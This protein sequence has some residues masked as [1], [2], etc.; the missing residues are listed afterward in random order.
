LIETLGDLLVTLILNMVAAEIYQRLYFLRSINLVSLLLILLLGTTVDSFTFQKNL[1]PK[2]TEALITLGMIPQH[3]TPSSPS[4]LQHTT[5]AFMASAAAAMD[6]TS[7]ADLV[8]DRPDALLPYF[9]VGNGLL[10]PQTVKKLDDKARISNNSNSAIYLFLDTYKRCGPMACL[11]M[12][13]DPQV[14][15]HL[16]RALRESYGSK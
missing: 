5:T 14:L 15:P 1:S 10:S 6:L 13:S 8:F 4:Q 11:P 16:T 12:L 9:Q 7:P 3:S 2:S